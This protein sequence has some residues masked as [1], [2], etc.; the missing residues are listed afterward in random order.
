MAS[1]L[2]YNTGVKSKTKVLKQT[3]KPLMF[4]LHRFIYSDKRKVKLDVLKMV[5]N[6]EINAAF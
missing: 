2:I 5:S 3:Q 4:E 6:V 1:F